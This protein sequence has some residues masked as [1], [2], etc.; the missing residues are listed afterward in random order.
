MHRL[1]S[2]DP[3][4]VPLMSSSM[5]L[6][7]QM[8]MTG[9]DAVVASLAISSFLFFDTMEEVLQERRALLERTKKR[10]DTFDEQ[11]WAASEVR[12]TPGPSSPRMNQWIG[13]CKTI[14]SCTEHDSWTRAWRMKGRPGNVVGTR[15]RIWR[16]KNTKKTEGRHGKCET[17]VQ[18][19]C[20]CPG[21]ST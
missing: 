8:A 21:T 20:G 12:A 11:T 13:E 16:R 14:A 17:H 9:I 5:F 10:E 2:V 19:R 4:I 18:T 3:A 15:A 7:F 1:A 6:V